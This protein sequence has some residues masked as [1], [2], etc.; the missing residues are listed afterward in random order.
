MDLK[1][2]KQRKKQRKGSVAAVSLDSEANLIWKAQAKKGF[3]MS[4]WVSEQLKYHH[5]GQLSP[6]QKEELLVEEIN[7]LSARRKKLIDA[8]I[9]EYDPMLC[10]KMN[11]LDK[12]RE[13]IAQLDRER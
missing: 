9:A 12:L 3:N 5:S 11:E 2:R 4:A 6:W 13:H 7:I 8:I 1:R 10:T